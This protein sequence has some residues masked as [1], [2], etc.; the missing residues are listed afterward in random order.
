[1]TQRLALAMGSLVVIVALVIGIPG[2]LVYRAIETRSL[3]LGMQRDALVL[4]DDLAGLPAA[5]WQQRLVL[6]QDRTGARLAVV[7]TDGILGFDTEGDQPGTGFSRPEINTALT[8]QIV[9]GTRYSNTLGQELYYAAVP[10]RS[11][12]EIQGALRLSMPA[13][14]VAAK[15]ERLEWILV[16]LM[17]CLIIVAVVVSWLMAVI[18]TRPLE[19]LATH[20]RQ[21]GRNPELAGPIDKGPREIREVS[22]ALNDTSRQLATSLRRMSAV[23]EESS[24]HLRTPLTTLRLRI[25][26]ISDV[27]QGEI[28]QEA[29]A[30]LVE[31][32]RLNARIEQVLAMARG[33]GESLA[34]TPA[35]AD[36]V[37]NRLEFWSNNGSHVQLALVNQTDAAVAVPPEVI[38]QVLDELIGNALKY[39]SSRIT[40]E[41]NTR[42]SHVEIA[43][44][45]DGPGIPATEHEAVFGR[46]QQGSTA[47]T[48]GTG[49]GLAMAREALNSFGGTCRVVPSAVGACVVMELP[50]PS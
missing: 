43:V 11:G 45:D 16:S 10:I 36:V 9:S 38:E 27:S 30:A 17:V 12:G 7:N 32:D 37:A 24:H 40:I 20:A 28:Q 48:E 31:I 2:I 33:R 50:L 39:A 29:D 8:G 3:Q 15:V 22:K 19:T 25:E 5:A 42:S 47:H 35:V 21:L 18:L 1:M 4:A 49:L 46:Y 41:V 6:Y 44:A 13:N 23:A 26:A 34:L 14:V